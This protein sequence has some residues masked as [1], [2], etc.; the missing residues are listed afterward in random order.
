MIIII[1]RL[2]RD[3][4]YEV[5]RKNII[6]ETVITKMVVIKVKMERCFY[7]NSNSVQNKN[8]SQTRV[9][10]VIGPSN[11]QGEL[12]HQLASGPEGLRIRPWVWGSLS[13][14]CVKISR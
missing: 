12:A 3:Y 9:T 7:A 8:T 2:A 11:S 13:V 6:K 14:L 1:N 5:R 10:G 4:Y